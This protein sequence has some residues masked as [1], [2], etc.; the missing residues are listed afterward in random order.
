MILNPRP[1]TQGPK[2][3]LH[4]IE[5]PLLIFSY[6]VFLFKLNMNASLSFFQFE[7]LSHDNGVNNPP[8]IPYSV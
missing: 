3:L 6:F 2:S 1:G 7:H 4:I 8:L 5:N